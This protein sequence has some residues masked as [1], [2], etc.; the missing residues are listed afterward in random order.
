MKKGMSV[1]SEVLI[2]CY[3]INNKNGFSNF[4]IFVKGTII[5]YRKGKD[6]HIYYAVIDK[7]GKLYVG[8]HNEISN[9]NYIFI[10]EEEYVEFLKQKLKEY[11]YK[12]EKYSQMVTILEEDLK[13]KDRKGKVKKKKNGF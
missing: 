13:E 9:S 5:D 11:D 7:E 3:S 8:L 1:G 6:G 12:K 2:F 4:D 10:T